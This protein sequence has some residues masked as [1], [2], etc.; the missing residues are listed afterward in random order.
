MHSTIHKPQVVKLHLGCGQDYWPGY[1]NIDVLPNSKADMVMSYLE[2]DHHFELNSVD[3]IVMIHSLNYVPLWEAR[4]FFAKAQKILRVGGQFIIETVNLEKAVRHMLENI[5]NF[6]Q[7][8]EGVRGIYGFGLD[9][10]KNRE[11]YAPNVQGWTAW[12]LQYELSQAGFEEI[13]ILPVQTHVSWRDM[14]VVATKGQANFGVSKVSEDVSL[15]AS[16]RASKGRVLFLLDPV[17][18]HV[19]IHLRGLI[20]KESFQQ[21]GWRVEYVNIQEVEENTIV[22]LSKNFDVV[23]LLKTA[24]LSLVKK[25][26]QFSSAKLI[27]DLTDALWKPFHRQAG[28]QDLEK[29]LETVDVIFSENEY[30]CAYGRKFKPYVYSLPAC[31]QI[32]RLDI[33]R[34]QIEP[35][36]DGKVRIGWIGSAGTVSAIEAIHVP[37]Q[38]ILARHPEVELRLLGCP[39]NYVPP[40]QSD[41][42]TILPNYNEEDMLQEILHLDI[43]LFP[44]PADLEDYAVRGALKAMLYMSGG[45]V[46]VCQRVGDC[47]KIIID[48]VTGMLASNLEEWEA[49]LE[50]LVTSPEQRQKFGQRGIEVIREKH[51]LP[52]VFSRT[53]EALTCVI[54]GVEPP[55]HLLDTNPVTSKGYAAEAKLVPVNSKKLRLLLIA[56]VPNWIFARHCHTL[57]RYLSDEF[58]IAI[59]YQG[60]PYNEDDFDLI[61]PLEWNLVKPEQIHN[62]AKYVTGIR[63]HVSWKNYNFTGFVNYLATKF[64]QVHVVSQRL[65]QIFAPQLPNVAYVTHGID[66]TFFTPSTSPAQTEQ[67]M[68]IGWA[69]NRKSAENKGF[70]DILEPLGRLPGVE[71]IYCGYS[72]TLLSLEDMRQFYDSLDIYI[73]ASVQEGSNNSLLEAAAMERAIITTDNGTVPEYLQNG[74][75]A[76]IVERQL[77]AFIQAVETLRDNPTQRVALGKAARMAVINGWDWRQKVEDYRLFFRK[78]LTHLG[79]TSS[80]AQPARSEP[81]HSITPST[82]PPEVLSVLAEVEQYF[83]QSNFAAARD[84]L[85]QALDLAPDNLQLISVYGD[86]LMQLGELESA[87]RQ[88]V[89]ATV[90]YPD[91][92]PAYVDLAVTLLQLNR[93]EEAEIALQRVLKSNPADINALKVWAQLC[94][95]TERYEEGIKTYANILQDNPAE[96]DVLLALGNCYVE[97]EDFASAL[98]IYQRIFVLLP[99]GELLETVR[100]TILKL[101]NII[102]TDSSSE[103]NSETRKLSETGA[104]V[105]SAQS[106]VEENA[107]PG[108]VILAQLQGFSFCIITAGTRPDLLNLVIKSI[109]V[110]NIPNYEIIVVGQYHPEP[111]I[112]YVP[113]KEAAVSG[114]LSQMRNLG[115]DKAK[116]DHIVILD[117]DIILTTNWYQAFLNFGDNFDILTSRILLPDGTRYWDHATIDGPRG[118]RLLR[119]DEQDEQYVYMSGGTA[120]IMKG[121]VAQSVRWNETLMFNEKE[122]VDFARKCQA[123]NFRILHNPD[124]VAYHHAEKYTRLGRINLTRLPDHTNLWLLSRSEIQTPDTLLRLIQEK[125]AN[126]E[127]AELA[128]CLRAGVQVF[129]DDV[130][131]RNLWKDLEQMYGGDV[132]GDRWYLHGDPKFAELINTL[133]QVELP[134][135]TP[136]PAIFWAASLFDFSGYAWL[137][138]Q[139]LPTLAQRDVSLQAQSF[140]ADE[141]LLAQLKSQPTVL[142]T[143]QHLLKQQVNQGVYV[144]FHPPVSWGGEDYFAHCRKHNPGFDAYIG[145]TMFETDRLPVGWADACNRMDEIWVPATF[146][147]DTFITAGVNP[148]KLQVIPFGLDTNVYDP[149][150]VTPLDIPEKRGF[151]FL[152]VFQW[153]KRKGWD[154]LLKA[155]LSVFSADDDV[156]LIIRAY[157]GNIKEPTLR[158]RLDAYITGLGYDL[159]RI[160]PIVLVEQ[161]IAESDMPAL[162]AAADAFVLPTRGEG[163]GIPF[164]EAMAMGRPVIGTRWSAHL[165]FMNDANSYL[166]DI[167]GLVPV[168]P[169]QTQEN[170][171]YTSDQQWAEPS[172]THTAAL[173]RHVFEQQTEAMAKGA[174]ARRDIQEHW[175][176]DRT[177][178]WIIGRVNHL[179]KIRL[180]NRPASNDKQTQLVSNSHSP[181]VLWHAPI[182]D[183]S[184]YAD[185]ARNFILQLRAQRI[186]ISASAIGRDSVT[187]RSQLAPETQVVLDQALTHQPDHNYISL[188]HFPA[189]AF[190]RIPQAAYNIGRVMFE[191]D[192]LPAD[193]VAKCNQMDE[194][195]VPTEFNLQTFRNAGITAKLVK[196]P[197]GI[198]TDRFRP[199]LEPLP[200]PGARGQVFLSIFEWGYRKGWDVLLRA[201]AKAFRPSDDVCLVLRTYPINQTDGFDAQVEIEQRINH[202]LKRK[203]K[204]SRRKVAPI[205]VLGEQ[206]SEQDLP[207]LHAAAT[208]YVSCS[209]GEG[210]GRPQMQAMACGLPV[211]ATRWGGNLEFMTEANSLLLD[212]KAVVKIDERAEIPFYRGQSWAEP[213]VEHLVTLLRHIHDNPGQA[214]AIG[215]QA[216]QDMV[217]KWQWSTVAAIAAERLQTIQTD[218]EAKF[219]HHH[220]TTQPITLRWEGSQF[221]VHSL[222]LINREICLRLAQDKQFDLSVI[223]Y[224]THQF[225]PEVD[226]RFNYIEKNLN[227]SLSRPADVHI[228]H[229]W[230]PDLNPPAE[231]HWVMIQPWEFGSLPKEW[232]AVM[233]EKVDEVWAYTHYVRNC[234]I[235]SGLPEDRVFVVPP[236]V[237]THVFRPDTSPLSLKTKKQFKFLFV[238][239][240]IIRKGIDILLDAYAH[241]FTATDDVCLVIKDMGGQ[242]FYQGRTAQEMITKIQ[243]TSGAPEI[244]YIDRTLNE[245]ELAGLYTA[246]DCLVHPYRGE[247]FGLPIAEAMAAGL[248]V[249]VTGYG[250]ALDFCDHDNAYLIPARMVQLPEKRIGERETVD[251]PWWAEPDVEALKVLL[252]RV[253]AQPQEAKAKAQKGIAHIR[254]NFSW[255]HSADAVKARLN[256]LRDKPIQR[257]AYPV[258][259][260]PQSPNEIFAAKATTQTSRDTMANNNILNNMIEAMQRAGQWPQAIQLLQEAVK[261]AQPDPEAAALWNSLGFCYFQTRQLSDAETAFEQGLNVDP[262]NLDLLHNLAELYLQQEAYDRATEYL[263]RALRVNPDDVNILLSL[264]HCALMLEAFDVALLAYHRVKTLAPETVGVDQI[265]KE[266]ELNDQPDEPS[267]TGYQSTN[268][269]VTST[270][271]TANQILAAGQTALEQG[272]L[273]RAAK[274]FAWVVVQYPSLAAAHMALGTTL[275]ALRQNEAAV[276]PFR[277][278]TELLPKLTAGHNQLGIALYRLGQLGEAEAAF[279]QANRLDPADLEPL[280][281]LVDLYRSQQRYEKA[282]EAVKAALILDSS[283][284]DVLVAFGLLS[285]ERGDKE[286]AEM[287]WQR[288]PHNTANHPGVLA[289]GQSLGYGQPATD[290]IT[291]IIAQVEAAQ[292]NGEWLEG[293]ALLRSFLKQAQSLPLTDKAVLLNRLGY[294]HF[295]AGQLTE[296]EAAF[297]QGLEFFPNHLDLLNNLA[298]FYVQQEQFDQATM[299]LNQALSIAPTDI[300]L[301]LSLGQCAIQLEAYDVALLAFQR[302]QTLAPE[303]EGVDEVVEQ[304]QSIEA[305]I[306]GV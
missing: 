115:V 188:I 193:W 305:N 3:E 173:M 62:P 30:I 37:L 150:K 42:F 306:V 44:P 170:P 117:D 287:A 184:G 123:E 34:T 265:I 120:W 137:S 47:E 236:G 199:G 4:D 139:I 172:V 202:F 152:S 9:H 55:L 295:M 90:F 215:Q 96:V 15:P 300:Q 118:H 72:D 153:S 21:Y 182:Y 102:E 252:R 64:Q 292:L 217:E 211:I 78:A 73:C 39:A 79:Q 225:G 279:Q 146:N 166:I 38:N 277:H 80:S 111:G 200:I 273:E 144:I 244:E 83:Q 138:R 186:N 98:K 8:L 156:S 52:Y 269:N 280:L 35:R 25:L 301:L 201:W 122:D 84:V 31:T 220:S 36:N 185:E 127:V 209:R 7:Y 285:L 1:V 234:Y 75:S 57:E 231:G 274:E 262:Q 133:D 294:C 93:F 82:F 232:I 245:A 140:T 49:K 43:G 61:Y 194:I 267:T 113:A 134:V 114:A 100:D 281:N 154:I 88:F 204:L 190:Q 14:R 10:L 176:L 41:R 125:T 179:G 253:F 284:P 251:Y 290:S 230:P 198:D 224:E 258:A 142:A 149:A 296:A 33:L 304:L 71:L 247:G 203:L 77:P 302:V 20:F 110:Q 101:Q 298:D 162:Y 60:Q 270:Q 216:R 268:T 261:Y 32:E 223:P 27:F 86:T 255:D 164:M 207:R 70:S 24:S 272:D 63:S 121:Y 266:I 175:T 212:V 254:A 210:W 65:Y 6:N 256:I 136:V 53:V 174:Q 143:W 278:L 189:Y 240:T 163:W 97:V 129:P 48:G 238:G 205:I 108:E 297:K 106:I 248:P 12:H 178:N 81:I 229:Q 303:T 107:S 119:G 105:E 126:Q 131:F 289:L 26:K 116:Y 51:S 158:E 147:R 259:T 221:V 40:V 257:L 180:S 56:D 66:T 54:N 250:A 46:P 275:L 271:E 177:A 89:K 76:L 29:I 68:R 260:K 148:A 109:R 128:D 59:K 99:P 282:S 249:I 191:S 94:L 228:R 235:Q 246:C 241:T 28:W 18:G 222:A 167:E 17:M 155:Y 288:L 2:I 104:V 214:A 168:D 169:E 112:I 195:W 141:K 130:R 286:G 23:Y 103:V 226:P 69:G 283:H 58:D 11:K 45:V 5:G 50:A 299:Y 181:S 233:Q 206:V 74:V 208:A 19:T 135:V 196:I 239:G 183:P 124:N 91:Y 192:G 291:L 13:E 22:E 276:A 242:S 218:L 160:P 159:C 157:S 132:L 161:F 151:T 227:R 16:L 165:D 263:N 293:I 87:R 219:V 264:G 171:F 92:I 145:I 187:F 67:K 243:H 197:G 213:S 85:I 237:D 95:N